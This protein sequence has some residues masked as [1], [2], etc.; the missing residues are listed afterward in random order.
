VPFFVC[1]LTADDGRV[2]ART[3]A[4]PSEAEV[5][6]HFESEGL[7]VLSIRRDWRRPRFAAFAFEKKIKARDFIMFNQE[8]MALF[9]AGYPVL[10][11]LEVIAGRTKN[12]GLK[13]ILKKVENDI[14]HGR[15]LSES[16]APFEKRFSKIYTA[17]L[18]AGEQ[19]GNLPETIGQFIV[20]AKTIDRTRQRMRSALTYPT[21]LFFFSLGLLGVL[22]NFVLPNF[23]TFYADFETQLPFITS[24]L[25][26]FSLF[27]RRLWWLWLA[28]TALLIAAYARFKRQE[29][30]ALWIDRQKLRL[31]LGKIVW[32]ESA[33]ALFS[34]T[35]SLLIGAGVSLLPA[36][37]LATQAIPNKYLSSKTTTIPESV[38][39]GESLSDA[40]TKAGV[41]PS[42]ALDM[43][44]IGE[45]SA[46]LGG[47]L[48]EVA[49]VYDERIQAKIDTLVSLIEP[50]VIVF[51]GLLLALMLLAVYL[52]I[53]NIIKVAR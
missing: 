19:S 39:N 32:V 48:R 45:T 33:V 6:R 20:Y 15:S 29:G 35:L 46:N 49:E 36:V 23:A 30:A 18:M 7:L 8:F 5:R 42:L 38:Q 51:M 28:L 50:I 14:R 10:K 43:I 44:R 26:D 24:L 34:R 22:L 52:P 37:G 13:D 9:R 41:F 40:M 12:P 1:R 25:I 16:F 2:F 31:P 11:S 17:A 27:V 47:M 3:L 4:A 21:L 53:F